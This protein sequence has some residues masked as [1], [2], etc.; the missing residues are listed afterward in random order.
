MV[1]FIP[2]G[3]LL[4]QVKGAG[5]P[6]GR[7]SEAW[8]GTKLDRPASDLGFHGRRPKLALATAALARGG[9]GGREAAT[10]GGLTPGIR[11]GLWGI[12][13]R[14]R[15]VRLAPKLG[16]RE[17]GGGSCGRYLQQ[18][19]QREAQVHLVDAHL[20]HRLERLLHLHGGPSVRPPPRQR[21]ARP[22]P[23][24]ARPP[25]PPPRR[26]PA[27]PSFSG[28]VRLGTPPAA[29]GERGA[30][31]GARAGRGGARAARWR[32]RGPGPR[33]LASLG[34][35][36]GFP[37]LW[38]SFKIS[39]WEGGL[40]LRQRRLRTERKEE[41]GFR[42]G[43]LM[44]NKVKGNLLVQKPRPARRPLRGLWGA[45]DGWE[46]RWPVVKFVLLYKSVKYRKWNGF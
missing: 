25:L 4:L 24:P 23:A 46:T 42:C 35:D 27:W 34:R 41:V 36:T 37:G 2:P 22:G 30:A 28:P 10:P 26:G 15:G 7:G 43:S 1:V 32:R 8:A 38:A 18:H 6:I 5:A 12:A 33:E 17:E 14:G 16:V 13:G 44:R 29:S 40:K 39:F 45:A 11:A 3:F 31:W 19:G 21:R 9:G 20:A